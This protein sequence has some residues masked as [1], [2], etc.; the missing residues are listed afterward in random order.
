MPDSIV[1]VMA[2]DA[3]LS[4]MADFALPG[5]G[6]QVGVH[7]LEIEMSQFFLG[8]KGASWQQEFGMSLDGWFPGAALR[9]GREFISQ[10]KNGLVQKHLQVWQW[11]VFIAHNGILVDG[12]MTAFH[13]S[14][15]GWFAGSD[16]SV[17]N[18]QAFEPEAEGAG[19]A[20]S[21]RRRQTGFS[22]G[23]HAIGQSVPVRKGGTEGGTDLFHCD[24]SR[25]HRNQFCPIQDS[26]DT[27]FPK[28]I[29][30]GMQVNQRPIA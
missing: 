28:R 21:L 30:H 18:I 10:F 1:V 29:S 26:S 3:N 27:D 25:M 17:L 13:F 20:I 6:S 22:I 2:A 16:Q 9:P 11:V 4:A 7:P 15:I 19:K 8:T 5:E 12:A 24:L 14:V 23:L